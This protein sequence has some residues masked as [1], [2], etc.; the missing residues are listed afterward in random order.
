MRY[1]LDDLRLFL[2]IV[3]EGSITAGA[4]R[5]HLSLPSAS[6]RVRSLERHAGVAL[7]IRSRRGV[8]PTPAGTTLA[9]HARDV[10]AQTARLES[11]VASYTQSPTAPLTL[12][13]GGSAMH[14]LVPRA[15]VAF[16]RA[17]P[18]VDVTV[19]ESRT[20]Q[21]VRMLADGEA[22]LGVVLD[23]EARD[24]GLHMEPLGDDSLVVIGQAGGILAGRTTLTY[25]EVAEHPLVGLDADSSLRR[26]IEKHLGPHAP[27]VRYRTTVANL[28]VLVTLAAAGV[29]L[30][31]VPRRAIDPHQPL[32]VCELQDPWARR[33]HLLAWGV[34]D[35]ASPTA[36]AALAEHLCRAALSEPSSRN[37][38][39]DPVGQRPSHDG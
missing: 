5:M 34:K 25:S 32:D 38:H 4:H 31:V 8:R 33:H 9:R 28:N 22:D 17:H 35:S 14:R 15:L 36:T 3:T 1:D 16:L 13:G 37:A 27:V 18:D 2:H 23:D 21:T 30:A 7:L 10:L 6:A 39:G 12:L 29:G 19:S 11:A 26:W 20:P 24:C